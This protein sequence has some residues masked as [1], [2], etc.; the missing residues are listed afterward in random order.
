MQPGKAESWKRQADG[1]AE[2]RELLGRGQIWGNFGME[3][4]SA[5][6]ILSH[7]AETTDGANCS[8]QCIQALMLIDCDTDTN[9]FPQTSLHLSQAKTKYTWLIIC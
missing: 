5:W 6:V 9:I 7:W 4:C 8:L 3:F 2:K 1:K